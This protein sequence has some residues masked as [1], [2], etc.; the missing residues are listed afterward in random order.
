VGRTWLADAWQSLPDRSETVL[1]C[2][3]A[4]E[5]LAHIGETLQLTRE[6]VR[7]LQGI[8]ER[9]LLNAQLR[10]APGLPEQLNAILGDRL[11]VPDEEIAHLIMTRVPPARSALLRALGIARPRTWSGDLHGWWTRHP[12]F[13]DSRLRRLSA[14][15]P[16][17]EDEAQSAAAELDLP[18][19]LPLSELLESPY[20][21]LVHHQIGWIRAARV[22]RDL[23][24]L[25]LR[26]EGE[27]RP[28][29]D[30]AK[31]TGTSEHAI[32][33]TMRRDD[34]FAQVRP[35]GTWALADWRV[36]RADNRYANAVEVVVEVLRDLGPLNY[37][38]LRAESQQ[39]YPVTPWRITQCLS[40]HMIG[41]TEDGLY[42]LAERGAQPIEDAEPKQPNTIKT[43]G[44]VVGVEL[45]VDSEMLRGSGINVSRWLTWYLGLRTA[46]SSRYFT[47]AETRDELT[48][49]RATSASQLSS[50]RLAVQRMD[51]VEGCKIA[52]LLHLDNDTADLRHMCPAEFCPAR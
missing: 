41:L 25:W 28:V 44:Q 20:S 10:H 16:M 38:Q 52:L 9:A 32:R 42:D 19:D 21:K 26:G 14:L 43:Q 35:E 51:L 7:Q 15:A 2:R 3:L 6:R 39:R 49:R 5:T 8:A 13:L 30:I 36:S 34:A 48:V 17:S 29:S 33:E 24:Y 11:A 31:I 40:S 4:G 45:D 27:P 1:V 37:Q 22:G 46:P 50:L 18:N 47:L 23:A 12:A